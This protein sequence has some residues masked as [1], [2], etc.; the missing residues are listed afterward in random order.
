MGPARAVT[1]LAVNSGERLFEID[2]SADYCARSMTTEAVFRFL[3][4]KRT[5]ER[6]FQRSRNF[7]RRAH[8]KVQT[9]DLLIKTNQTLV[10]FA[11]ILKNIGL[12]GPAITKGI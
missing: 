2:L 7:V 5:A 1:R 4:R 10:E 12:S 6:F 3:I 9:G 8:G 11:L